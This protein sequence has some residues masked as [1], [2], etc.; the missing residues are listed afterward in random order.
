MNR[1]RPFLYCGIFMLI[2]EI[3]KQWC[4]TYILNGGSYNWW[5]FPF[6]LCSIPMYIC[7]A[8]P[9]IPSKQLRSI[10]L[11]FLM[12]FGLL[13]GIFAFF[14]TAGM[15]YGYAPL[16][17][18]SFGWHILLIL[19]GI[20]AGLHPDTDHSRTGYIGSILFYLS[21]CLIATTVNLTFDRF[22]LINMFYINPHYRMSQKVF[23]HIALV[24]GNTAGIYSYILATITGAGI[25]HSM[26]Y[27]TQS[28][29]R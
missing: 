28:Q 18:H 12:D 20:Y 9:W 24:W 10:L 4:L 6:Q 1:Y 13:G 8:L 17:I 5:Y 16:T 21:C 3:W 26:W 7:L 23:C 27:K 2:S 25:L 11:A 29:H 14:D 19:L 15:H 22:D